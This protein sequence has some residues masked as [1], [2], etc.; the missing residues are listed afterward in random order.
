MRY[1][2]KPVIGSLLKTL[3]DHHF[4]L[5]EVEADES[6]ALVLVGLTPRQARQLHLCSCERTLGQQLSHAVECLPCV[7]RHDVPCVDKPVSTTGAL[8]DSLLYLFDIGDGDFHGGA[9][10]QS[11]SGKRPS[12]S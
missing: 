5:R 1:N 10:F 12:R 6:H 8:V 3:Q 4:T 11:S 2:W 9:W 7:I